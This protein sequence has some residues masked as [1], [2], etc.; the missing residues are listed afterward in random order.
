MIHPTWQMISIRIHPG[1]A[2]MTLGEVVDYFT[3]RTAPSLVPSP[4]TPLGWTLN[5][6]VVPLILPFRQRSLIQFQAA[7]VL[8]VTLGGSLQMSFQPGPDRFEIAEQ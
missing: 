4:G 8:L 1:T 3:S 5:F 6:Y 2:V 7:G